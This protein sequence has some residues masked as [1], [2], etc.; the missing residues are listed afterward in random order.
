[1]A[2]SNIQ[3]LIERS[4]FEAIRKVLINSGYLPD[5]NN[6]PNTQQ[7]DDQYKAAIDSIASV[8][9]FAAEIFGHSS[10]QSKELKRTPRIVMITRRAMT[11]DIGNVPIAI[12]EKNPLAPDTRMKIQPD[13]ETADLQIDIHCVSSSADQDR[14]VNAVLAAAIG[15]R[16]F[17]QL[18]DDPTQRF[19]I[20]QYSAYDLP[21][22]QE[23]I[24]ERISSYEIKDL[25]MFD[26]V[27]I[28]T[29]VPPIKQITAEITTL[30]LES[31][32]SSQSTVIGPYVSDEALYIDLSGIR[33]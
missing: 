20:R 8:K 32:V 13:Q 17:L 6:Y 10:P 5:I 22:T 25:W 24:I 18:Y 21:D 12:Y 1:M 30:E 4:I 3:Q 31:I 33:F 11:G 19:F 28:S 16:A 29:N 23:G 7:G 2:L 14:V 15:K 26:G 27:V 9:K